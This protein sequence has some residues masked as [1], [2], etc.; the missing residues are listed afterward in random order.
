MRGSSAW[1][2][3]TWGPACKVDIVAMAIYAG[4]PRFQCARIMRPAFTLLGAVFL[5]HSYVIHS[6]GCYNCR[7]I[8]GGTS[9][10]SHSWGN[11]VDVNEATNPYRRDRLVTDM[12]PA[13]I[14]D[15]YAIRTLSGLQA[16]R[17]GGDWDGR[18]DTPHS[19]YDA[20]HFEC[21][22]T[23]EE[24]AE[25]FPALAPEGEAPVVAW[26]VIRKGAVG[27]AVVE[28]QRLLSLDAGSAAGTFGPRT[29]AAVRLYQS[30][31]G[32]EADGIVGHGTWTA[33]LTHQPAL[34]T[35]APAPRK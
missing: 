1:R 15:V 8:T 24:L 26:P 3:E 22:L 31:H 17:W 14:A 28:L 23:P 34:S 35:G 29:E 5:R 16:F 32:L 7:P 13:M 33:L 2:L 27:P 9:F 21:V 12:A 20:M 10:S 4:G 25:G 18:A 19:N 30:R 6:A 11:S